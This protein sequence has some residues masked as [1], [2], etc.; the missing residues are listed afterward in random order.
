MNTASAFEPDSGRLRS[1]AAGLG[2]ATTAV[3]YTYTWDS[4]SNLA[5]RSDAN[6]D[7]TRKAVTESFGYDDLNRLNHYA[8]TAPAIPG[9]SRQVT[10]QYNAL[11]SLLFKSDVGVY[12]YNASGNN[13]AGQSHARLHALQSITG[14][15]GTT[16]YQYD[17]DGNLFWASSGKYQSITYTSFGLPDSS[18]GIR[19]PGGSP[20]YVW[21]Y[22][23][24]HGRFKELR[25]IVGGTYAGTRTT[26]YLHP[27]PGQRTLATA[28]RG[29]APVS[30][31]PSP[32]LRLY[33]MKYL[34][35]C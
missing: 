10:L 22:D 24:N 32:Y 3:D 12:A 18:S 2:S 14:S 29:T 6:G 28:I 25:T 23:E 11:G 13:G 27:D 34:P 17:D 30:P 20:S 19:A 5:T 35:Y 16:S 15:S 26:W 7:G 4:L 8:V 21:S 1:I 33:S 9:F 31:P